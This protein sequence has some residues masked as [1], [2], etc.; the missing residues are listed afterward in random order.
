HR[1]AFALTRGGLPMLPLDHTCRQRSCCNPSH[2][3]P[4]SYRENTHRTPIAPAAVNARKWLCKNG[5]PLSG[6]NLALYEGGR[7]RACLA[8]KRERGREVD[9]RRYA[10]R[11]TPEYL[12]AATERSRLRRD[13]IRQ[14]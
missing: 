9:R 14:S 3:D 2:A 7:R 1:G 8:C 5:H 6:D 4:V 13:R 12:A 10:K 11:S